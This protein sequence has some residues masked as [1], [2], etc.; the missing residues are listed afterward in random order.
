MYTR[1]RGVRVA[2][3]IFG[4]QDD[5]EQVLKAV[6]NGAVLAE[7]QDIVVVEGNPYF[8]AEAVNR[9]YVRESRTQT[10]CPWKGVASYYTVIVNGSENKDAAWFYPEP[11]AAAKMIQDRV[12]FWKGVEIVE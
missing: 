11:T 8:P 10:T 12:A 6:W 5:R 7:S 4:V 1:E 2:Q 9:Q 3:G